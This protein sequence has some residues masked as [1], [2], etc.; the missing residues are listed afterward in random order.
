M[1]DGKKVLL[2]LLIPPTSLL[3][4]PPN[5]PLLL[6]LKSLLN[7]GFHKT[8][9]L[10]PDIFGNNFV[11]LRTVEQV[12]DLPGKDGFTILLLE[13]TDSET[14]GPGSGTISSSLDVARIVATGSVTDFGTE[15]VETYVERS[16]R[17]GGR[18][19]EDHQ[20]MKRGE[21]APT[22]VSPEGP[23]VNKEQVDGD[24]FTG[25]ENDTPNIDTATPQERSSDAIGVA[26]R[27]RVHKFEITAF[28]V[29]PDVQA[30][31]LGAR[32]LEEIKWVAARSLYGGKLQ[33]QMQNEDVL[34]SVWLE[35]EQ[36]MGEVKGVDLGKLKRME[37]AKTAVVPEDRSKDGGQDEEL[38]PEVVL[39][40]TVATGTVP[41][42]MW[43]TRKDCT[44]VYMET[45][46]C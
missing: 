45:A 22:S 26:E 37:E 14:N 8:H 21:V 18:A 46:K 5:L 29:D 12:S 38:A 32:V 43:G 6:P 33:K 11:R 34:R 31:G 27:Q 41:A 25:S 39:M 3:P 1:T 13:I 10:R 40:C 23:E 20:D 19:W 2:S 15:A 42:G 36:G 17:K 24:S 30:K 44:W 35:S 16:K 4:T 28:T 7:K 9:S